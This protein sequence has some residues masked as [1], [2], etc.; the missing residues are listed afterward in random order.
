[1]R[2]FEHEHF[3]NVRA[4]TFIVELLL[5][6]RT[7]SVASPENVTSVLH[8]HSAPQHDDAQLFFDALLSLQVKRLDA[9][10]RVFFDRVADIC[11]ID[12]AAVILI[13]HRIPH[14]QPVK[15]IL[16]ICVFHFLFHLFPFFAAHYPWLLGWS[17]ITPVCRLSRGRVGVIAS[18][19]VGQQRESA[20]QQF[21]LPARASIFDGSTALSE[22]R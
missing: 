2:R 21:R 3:I 15:V 18:I 20:R 22:I 17:V 14:G 16:F 11:R 12:F 19:F 5:H 10:R 13:F 4:L 9:T 7:I 1:M 6:P 8:K